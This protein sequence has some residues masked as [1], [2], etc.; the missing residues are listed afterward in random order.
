MLWDK[1]DLA[2]LH[3]HME[4]SGRGFTINID[5]MSEAQHWLRWKSLAGGRGESGG[6]QGRGTSWSFHL[7]CVEVQARIIDFGGDTEG[8][9]WGLWSLTSHLLWRQLLCTTSITP[10]IFLTQKE[11]L[12]WDGSNRVTCLK[13]FLYNNG[14]HASLNISLERGQLYSSTWVLSIMGL[15][16]KD[17]LSASN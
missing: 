10:Y 7:G 5:S 8:V 9:C 4:M 3:M 2:F 1:I 15:Y 17:I 6:K 16:Q 12:V 13:P 11:G 14:E